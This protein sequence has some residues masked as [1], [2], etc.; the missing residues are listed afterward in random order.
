MFPGIL[1]HKVQLFGLPDYVYSVELPLSSVFSDSSF[2]SVT[3]LHS[4]SMAL[5]GGLEPRD[6]LSC[7]YYILYPKMDI[8][9]FPLLWL[10]DGAPS[11]RRSL[12]ACI[13]EQVQVIQEK[14]N[15]R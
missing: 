3:C 4:R 11:L 5:C 1:E 8:S 2:L 9:A 10:C 13:H 6:Q 7:S 15:P 12:I 14:T